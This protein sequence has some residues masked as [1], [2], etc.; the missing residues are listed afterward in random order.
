MDQELKTDKRG[1]SY[2][3]IFLGIWLLGVGL[4]VL[5]DISGSIAIGGKWIGASLVIGLGAFFILCSF[6]C[7]NRCR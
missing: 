7:R 5:L 2:S 4:L 1:L 6:D 3:R